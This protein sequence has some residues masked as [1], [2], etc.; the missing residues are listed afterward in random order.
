LQVS[1]LTHPLRTSLS[2]FYQRL[3]THHSRA[4]HWTRVLLDPGTCDRPLPATLPITAAQHAAT[5]KWAVIPALHGQPAQGAHLRGRTAPHPHAR[6]RA[7]VH[8]ESCSRKAAD[9]GGQA[10]SG[11]WDE[12]MRS[13]RFARSSPS[14][15]PSPGPQHAWSPRSFHRRGPPYLQRCRPWRPS[16]RRGHGVTMDLRLHGLLSPQRCRLRLLST[17]RPL[18]WAPP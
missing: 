5:L 16:T 11:P 1:G 8:T 3:R 18:G 13:W 2:A 14:K 15:R 6:F 9:Y 10:H 4:L 12:L 7:H 17:Q